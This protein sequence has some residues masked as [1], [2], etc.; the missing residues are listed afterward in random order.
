MPFSQSLI[1]TGAVAVVTSDSV[2]VGYFGLYIGGGGN[3]TVS[4]ADGVPVLFQDVPAGIVIPM[5]VSRVWATGTTA[6]KMVGF[7]R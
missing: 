3:L 1:P 5:Q 2:N 6:T 4:G 7:V